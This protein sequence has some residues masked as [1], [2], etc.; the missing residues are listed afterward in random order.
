MAALHRHEAAGFRNRGSIRQQQDG[1]RPFGQ[2]CRN[3]WP[4]QQR[5]EFFT[6]L[7]GHGRDSLSL[8]LCHRNILVQQNLIPP[9]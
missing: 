1:T 2:P 6:L 4:A 8:R 9:P 5:L 7:G 3:A